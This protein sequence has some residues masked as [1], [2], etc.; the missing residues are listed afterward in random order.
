MFLEVFGRG[1][2]L[3]KPEIRYTER[4]QHSPL[5]RHSALLLLLQ[6]SRG[7]SQLSITP[8]CRTLGKL[9]LRFPPSATIHLWK[10]KIDSSFCVIIL[11]PLT[12]N[13]IAN[14]EKKKQ[15]KNYIIKD[16]NHKREIYC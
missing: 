9:H 2:I 13:P 3:V 15:Q 6:G 1:K 4:V 14:K 12:G 8:E 11:S 10:K 16:N 7:S 5:P